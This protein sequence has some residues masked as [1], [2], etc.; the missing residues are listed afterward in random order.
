MI[1]VRRSGDAAGIGIREMEPSELPMGQTYYE[2]RSTWR[3]HRVAESGAR[4]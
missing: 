2:A 1:D 3:A 4:I